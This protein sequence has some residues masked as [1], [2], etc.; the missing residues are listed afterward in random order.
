LR[1]S[2]SLF[3]PAHPAATP[4]LLLAARPG[5]VREEVEF[6]P[7]NPAHSRRTIETFFAALEARD[8]APMKSLLGPEVAL[9]VAFA[10]NGSAEPY[11]THTGREA[12]L[13]YFSNIT[14][15]FSQVKLADRTTVVSEDGG[16]VFLECRGELILARNGAAYRNVYVFKFVFRDGVIA[17]ITEYAN[18]VILAKFAGMPLG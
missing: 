1:Y 14:Q 3:E 6:M 11:G 2:A 10:L 4:G 17:H 15:L 8:L 9:V 18:P 12:V 16:T 5:D 7:E 13:G